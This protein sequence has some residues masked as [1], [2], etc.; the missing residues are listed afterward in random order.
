MSQ[1]TPEQIVT[2]F[3]HALE[4]QDHDQI[5][6]LLAPNLHYTNVSLPTLKGG[7]KVANLFELLLRRGTGFQVKVHSIATNGNTVMTERT[8]VINVGPL[9]IGFW[10]CG[11]FQVENGKIVLW[12]D[13]FDWWDISRGTLRGMAGMILPKLRVSL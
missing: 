12:R 7:Q 1:S 10:V 4:T 11:T 8:D 2:Q 6:A 3:L 13:Y 9:H 5:A